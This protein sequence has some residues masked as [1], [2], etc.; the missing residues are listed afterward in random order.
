MLA[1]FITVRIYIMIILFTLNY[2]VVLIAENTRGNQLTFKTYMEK[3]KEEKIKF[4]WLAK[5]L[6][7]EKGTLGYKWLKDFEDS[8]FLAGE[9]KGIEIAHST[10]HLGMLYDGAFKDGQEEMK[11][12]VLEKV[13]LINACAS[14]PLYKAG[15]LCAI[16]KVIE[17]L[18]DKQFLKLQ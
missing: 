12:K 11:K 10:E 4:E 16:K 6:E 7:V 13:E 3:F 5:K 14:D 8:S 15:Y 9:E 1:L 17:L 18:K 2:F